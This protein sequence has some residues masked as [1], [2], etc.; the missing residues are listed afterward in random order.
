MAR[1]LLIRAIAP[2][3]R[4]TKSHR[5]PMS[6]VISFIDAINHGDVERLAGLMAEDYAVVFDEQPQVGRANGIEGWRGYATAYPDYVIHPH[7]LAVQGDTVAVLG[8]TTGSHL[9]LPDADEEK[10]TLIWLGVV[11]DGLIRRWVLHRRRAGE[12]RETWPGF[13][14]PISSACVR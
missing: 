7:R 4:R 1:I 12:P 3:V 11:T 6:T 10:L 2:R 14:G 8:H 5:L 13:S 9:G